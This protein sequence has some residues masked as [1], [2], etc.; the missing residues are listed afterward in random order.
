MCP[1]VAPRPRM[2]ARVLPCRGQVWPCRGRAPRPCRNAKLP[3]RSIPHA[4]ARYVARH[5]TR[6]P[7]P[8]HASTP[9]AFSCR[10]PSLRTGTPRAPTRLR[11]L[12]RAE[13]PAPPDCAPALCSMG[14]SPFQVLHLFFFHFFFSNYFQLLENVP[15]I[16]FIRFF[17]FFTFPAIG[18]Y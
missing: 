16:I 17:F 14:S 6:L 4:P 8:C 11:A 7:L 15:K 10:A 12:P 9:R 18:K 5:A 1:Q 2:T 3:Y 13:R